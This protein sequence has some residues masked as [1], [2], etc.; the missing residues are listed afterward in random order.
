MYLTLKSQNL[1]LSQF[2]IVNN[3]LLCW[4]MIFKKNMP[5]IDFQANDKV[6]LVIWSNYKT[7]NFEYT[8]ILYF[9]I[10]KPIFRI[11]CAHHIINLSENI[12]GCKSIKSQMII[13]FSPFLI[14]HERIRNFRFFWNYNKQKFWLKKFTK[15]QTLFRK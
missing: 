3:D 5:P 12:F 1:L 7:E 2:L 14:I 15:S 11:F 6:V 9:S 8:C 4:S 13:R 10:R